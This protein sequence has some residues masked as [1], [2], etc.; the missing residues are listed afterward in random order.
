MG[1]AP[2]SLQTLCLSHL[3]RLFWAVLLNFPPSEFSRG[4]SGDCGPSLL[5]YRQCL[6]K[7]PKNS[8]PTFFTRAAS[9]LESSLWRGGQAPFQQHP[10]PFPVG[11]LKPSSPG[12]AG[13][14]YAHPSSRPFLPRAPSV[15][16]FDLLGCIYAYMR[17]C[18][19]GVS[20]TGPLACFL[21]STSGLSP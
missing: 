2:L 3:M 6:A 20:L 18:S 4:H 5:K 19:G 8:L 1:G 14:G 7:P 15:T 9:G 13:S 10:P 11:P 12:S 17:G 21:I 16:F